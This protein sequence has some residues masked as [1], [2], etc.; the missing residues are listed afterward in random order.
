MRDSMANQ[1]ALRPVKATV[2]HLR[3][4]PVP[5]KITNDLP[6]QESERSTYSVSAWLIGYKHEA[7]SDYHLVVSE[8]GDTRKTMIAEMP[9]PKCAP[10]MAAKLK[11]ERDALLAMGHGSGSKLYRFPKPIPVELVGVLFFDKIHGQSGVAPN[12]VELH[13][14][15]SFVTRMPQ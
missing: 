2:T 13:P 10:R 3:A 14:L 15:L 9:D 8:V 6:R 1:V 11:S 4:L 7:D 12:G 5:A